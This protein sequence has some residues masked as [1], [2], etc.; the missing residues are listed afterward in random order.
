MTPALS[1]TSKTRPLPTHLGLPCE[2]D[3]VPHD[4]FEHLQG[5]LLT[6]TIELWLRRLRPGFD[7]TIGQDSFIY[8]DITTPPTLGAKAP[9]W[10]LVPGVPNLLD[11]EPRR[12]FVLWNEHVPPAVVMEF[13][14]EWPS[15]EWDKTPR[16]GKFW[17]YEQGICAQHY[18]I[19]D[20]KRDQL[21]AFDLV[22]GRFQPSKVNDRGHYPL[23]SL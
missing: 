12:S 11:G 16:T 15:G 6:S 17:V 3:S 2:D 21:D 8:W 20:P 22:N 7:C 14:S 10:F 4:F 9:D 5:M 1:T 23:P 19:F 13:I 18:V